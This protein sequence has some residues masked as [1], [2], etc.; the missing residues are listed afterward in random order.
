[1]RKWCKVLFSI[2]FSFAFFVISIGY[3]Q[4]ADT[5]SVTGTAKFK[6]EG[7]YITKVEEVSKSNLTSNGNEIVLPTNLKSTVT[8]SGTKARTI[9]YK[10]TVYN[11]SPK[12]AYSYQGIVCD[13]NLQG[14]SNNLYSETAGDNNLSVKLTTDSNGRTEFK[15]G[16]KIEPE[17]ELTFYATYT[18]GKSV[19]KNTAISVLLNFKFGI[20]VASLGEA[21]VEKT[22]LAFLSAL[23]NDAK[24]N[25][26]ITSIDDKY[27]GQA[28]QANYMGNV[29][30]V[31]TQGKADTAVVESLV[32]SGLT[33]TIDNV[34]KNI[35]LII[36]R[37]NL[38]GNTRTGDAYKVN[39][40][41][42][43]GSWVQE[44]SGTGCEMT[45]YMTPNNL[46]KNLDDGEYSSDKNYAEVYVSVTT[47]TNDG[48]IKSDGTTNI[49]SEW[50]QLGDIYYGIANIVAYNGDTGTGS[51]VTDNWVS[52][53]KTYKVTENYSYTIN[54]NQKISAIMQV[55]DVNAYNEFVRLRTLINTA[56]D[57]VDRNSDY[58]D[59]DEF[60]QAVDTL[61]SV[62]TKAN[63]LNITSST[64]RAEI[65]PI[66]RELENAVYPF[67]SYLK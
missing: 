58:F 36:K 62:A 56:V 19:T 34:T 46:D 12:Y 65:I 26:L 18:F 38:D 1:M 48:V 15:S 9:K 33:L 22:L 47:C 6:Y 35:T 44:T 53:Q 60:R 63:S 17:S 3:A 40:G 49:T 67:E 24:Y 50:Y 51:F 11:S 37:E 30:N 5:L 54:A 27:A 61:H 66:L 55:V 42:V 4:L 39:A 21:A 43:N 45:I 13:K 28:W 8:L 57:Y 2:A 16:T 7:V 10:I 25:T 32:G 14:Y 41:Y 59:I 29:D 20:H 23:N 52:L 31:T 64:R